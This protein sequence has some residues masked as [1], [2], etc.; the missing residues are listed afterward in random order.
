M[1]ADHRAAAQRR[2]ADIARARAPVW[3][4]RARTRVGAEASMPRPSAAAS[5]SIS[6]VPE[7][8]STLWLWCISSD[9]D[10]ELGPSA[11]AACLTSPA[12]RLTPSEKLPV[13]TMRAPA[14]PA[15][16][17]AA[18]LFLRAARGADDVD[19]PARRGQLAQRHRGSGRGEIDDRVGAGQGG[20]RIVADDDAER[21][22]CRRSRPRRGPIAGE[23]GRS[24]AE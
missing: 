3:P 22:R 18:V 9:L 23:P 13:L 2:K 16:A 6:A 8:A 19:Q 24:N 14:E 5:P 17:I 20:F 4:C 15:S 1:L 10:V 21:C 12:R 11:A 7:G